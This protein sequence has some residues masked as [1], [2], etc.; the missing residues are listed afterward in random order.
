MDRKAERINRLLNTLNDL[1][2]EYRIGIVLLDSAKSEI[3][4]MEARHYP[5][6]SLMRIRTVAMALVEEAV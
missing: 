4:A 2:A 6:Q 3:E 1:G 5:S